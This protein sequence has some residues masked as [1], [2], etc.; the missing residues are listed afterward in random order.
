MSSLFEVAYLAF[1]EKKT[2]NSIVETIQQKK[3][4]EQKTLD[5]M[6][7][8]IGTCIDFLDYCINNGYVSLTEECSQ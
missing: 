6:R 1:H 4:Y 7:F 8:Q 2:A 3:Q 5:T